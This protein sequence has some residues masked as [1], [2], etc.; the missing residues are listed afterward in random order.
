MTKNRI[1]FIIIVTSG[2]LVM[3]KVSKKVKNTNTATP[4]VS[5][6]TS[7]T[8]N[9]EASGKKEAPVAMYPMPMGLKGVFA[10]GLA[11]VDA[12]KD[13]YTGVTL[14]KL[15][16]GY[17]IYAQGACIKCHTA[18]SIYVYNEVN[19]GGIIDDMAMRAHI[20]NQEKDAVIKYVMSIKATQKN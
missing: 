2:L 16:E 6:N 18:K 12:I 14:E 3:C 15:K 8:S 4:V 19:W 10:P 9:N 13:K 1:A 11:E 7:T 17:T 5:T 20:T